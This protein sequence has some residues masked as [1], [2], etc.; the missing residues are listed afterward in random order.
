MLNSRG[1]RME[2]WGTQGN[3]SGKT[4][5]PVY[6]IVK[7]FTFADNKLPDKTQ[8]EMFTASEVKVHL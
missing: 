3:Y 2:P 6:Y 1:P 4:K 7:K 8:G 5:D